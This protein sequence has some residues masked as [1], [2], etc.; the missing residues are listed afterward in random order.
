ML[1][2]KLG[3]EL[4]LVAVCTVLRA[5]LRVAWFDVERHAPVLGVRIREHLLVGDLE[6]VEEEPVAGGLL[7][8]AG[9]DVDGELLVF[10]D[11]PFD[12]RLQ[13]EAA[14]AGIV[15]GAE[16]TAEAGGDPLDN[17]DFSR[18]E[19]F[20]EVGV[21]EGIVATEGRGGGSEREGSQEGF[22][23]CERGS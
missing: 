19:G 20:G 14:V 23:R 16:I 3:L 11:P 7:E 15:A 2:E 4:E 5:H 18:F 10:R 12:F 9:V 8:V 13:V 21:A 22:H 1:E 17:F 6:A